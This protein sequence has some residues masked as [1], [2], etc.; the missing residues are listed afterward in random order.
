MTNVRVGKRRLTRPSQGDVFREVEYIEHVLEGHGVLEV[1]KIVFP[2]VVVLTQDCDLQWDAQ[3]RGRRTT[4]PATQDKKLFSVLVAPLYNAEH[5]YQGQ[6]LTDIGL[7]MTMINKTAT[8]GKT[9][10]SSA[11]NVRSDMHH[12]LAEAVELKIEE[13]SGVCRVVG[14]ERS[15]QGEAFK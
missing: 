1:S 7:T 3:Y 11:L 2:L 13:P 14:R 6:H 15:W 4:R 10:G 9:L 12:E 8:P 5:V